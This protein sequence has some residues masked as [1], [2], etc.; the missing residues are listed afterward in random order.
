V[1]WARWSDAVKEAGLEPNIKQGRIEE[2]FFLTKI[3][4]ACRHFGKFPTAMELRMF[5]KQDDN[6]P[7]SKASQDTLAR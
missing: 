3:A 6:F 7:T 2:E 5:Q 1:F 4:E